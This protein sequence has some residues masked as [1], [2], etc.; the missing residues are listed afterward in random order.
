MNAAEGKGG[1]RPLSKEEFLENANAYFDS[2]ESSGK[3]AL[4][5]R[6]GRTGQRSV[7]HRRLRKK[8]LN[9]K[10]KPLKTRPRV[11]PLPLNFA[12]SFIT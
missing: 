9:T 10:G 4:P 1:G 12:D 11:D 6:S 2:K 7:L 5:V 8:Y 3:Q